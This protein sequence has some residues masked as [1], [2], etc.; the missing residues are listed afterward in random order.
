MSD[1][2]TRVSMMIRQD[3]HDSLREM[4]VNISGYIRDLIDDRLN[5]HTIVL[6]VDADTRR[7]YDQI[8]SH[9]EKGDQDFQPYIREALKKMLEE[10]IKTLQHLYKD[11]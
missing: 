1:D 3:Q 2:L 8:I 5:N 11:M 10:K 6:S 9:A 7:L 4:D